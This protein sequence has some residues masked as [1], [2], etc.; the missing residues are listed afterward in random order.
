MWTPSK[1][2]ELKDG[3]P[4]NYGMGF[5]VLTVNGQQYIG[6]SGGQQGTST[7]M[8]FVPGKHFAV[9][10]FAN[11][12]EVEPF[13]VVGPILDLYHMPNPHPKK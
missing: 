4:A 12:E 8:A 6:H 10:V 1:L 3:K 2:P 7:Y 5:G 9:A 13:D 11:E